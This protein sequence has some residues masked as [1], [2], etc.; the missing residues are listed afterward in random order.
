M[1]N[2]YGSEKDKALTPMEAVRKR[3]HMFFGRVDHYGLER[4]ASEL[5]SNALDQFVQ[6]YATEISI[7]SNESAIVVRDD[8]EG[9][10]LEQGAEFIRL[11]F[12]ELHQTPSADGHAPH[13]HADTNFGGVGLAPI[14][15]LAERLTVT[16]WRSGTR[17]RQTFSR[18]LPLG[19]AQAEDDDGRGCIIEFVPDPDIWSASSPRPQIIRA[20][21]YRL[22]RLFSPVKIAYGAETFCSNGGLADLLTASYLSELGQYPE[23]WP[24]PFHCILDLDVCK[25]E[26]AALGV[27]DG[28]TQWT[29]WVNGGETIDHG[30]HKEAMENCLQRIQ[31][32]P[33]ACL[34]HFISH[35]AAFSGPMKYRLGVPEYAELMEKA[36]QPN[37]QEYVAKH[38]KLLKLNASS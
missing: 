25:L 2:K 35:E 17:W 8:G 33:A 30:T 36:I 3:P 24:L 6:G 16:T 37:I 15:A 4:V 11:H 38:S 20:L 31:W 29:S 22:S 34:I 9:L 7:E 5:I 28:D 32:S 1:A 13:V 27:T 19:A 10:P 26:M 12:T 21:T 23:A 18:G 14:C